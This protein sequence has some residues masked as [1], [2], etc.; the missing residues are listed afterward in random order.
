MFPTISFLVKKLKYKSQKWFTT[1]EPV[2]SGPN[3]FYYIVINSPNTCLSSHSKQREK[4][5]FQALVVKILVPPAPFFLG[6]PSMPASFI[7]SHLTLDSP[8]PGSFT[9]AH[10]TKHCLFYFKFIPCYYS[11]SQTYL[12]YLFNK[13]KST[14]TSNQGSPWSA[15]F[16][17]CTL[18]PQCPKRNTYP[19]L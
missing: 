15:S 19:K 9:P 2:R 6:V 13:V 14:E 5:V 8:L 12:C 16:P 3:L 11:G 10:P 7:L 1:S 4:S 18:L 17:A